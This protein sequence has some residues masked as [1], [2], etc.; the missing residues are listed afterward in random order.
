M[1]VVYATF[2]PP[3]AS[4]SRTVA[5]P[6]RRTMPSRCASKGPTRRRPASELLSH[7]TMRNSPRQSHQLTLRRRGPSMRRAVFCIGTTLVVVRAHPLRC[8]VM[9]LRSFLALSV[10]SSSAVLAQTPAPAP[11]KLPTVERRI[12]VTATRL[13][14]E[15]DKVPAAIE[16]FTGDELRARGVH[17]LRDALSLAVGLE[18]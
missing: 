11:Q 3:S 2:I 12:E 10:A 15:P 6:R 8:W 17:D 5:S 4:N 7:L 14:E 1:T 9:R 16:V 18:I 13:P